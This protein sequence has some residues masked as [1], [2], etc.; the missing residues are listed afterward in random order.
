MD[1]GITPKWHSQ[2]W[3]CSYDI[4]RRSQRKPTSDHP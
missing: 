4:N 3:L 2:S 1:F